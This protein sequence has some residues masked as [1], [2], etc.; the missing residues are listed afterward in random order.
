MVFALNGRNPETKEQVSYDIQSGAYDLASRL[1]E[2]MKELKPPRPIS[3][4]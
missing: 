4:S 3:F 2:L 1:Q